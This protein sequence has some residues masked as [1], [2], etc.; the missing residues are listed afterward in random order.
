MRLS[1]QS[2]IHMKPHLPWPAN[3][4]IIIFILA[5]FLLPA[6]LAYSQE[7][8]SVDDFDNGL[9]NET[10][11]YENDIYNSNTEFDD[12]GAFAN[13]FENNAVQDSDQ[14]NSS[15]NQ[16]EF[17]QS[18]FEDP[19]A[20]E[21]AP[22]GADP[23]DGIVGQVSESVGR[24]DEFD[25]GLRAFNQDLRKALQSRFLRDLRRYC[26]DYCSL[27]SFDVASK[28]VFDAVNP[29]LGF[30][31]GASSERSFEADRVTADVLIDVRYGQRNTERLK[32][33]IDSVVRTYTFPIDV[34]WTPI[35]LP[36]SDESAKS[37][38]EVKRQ[39]SINIRAELERV[40]RDFCPDECS[41]T[42]LQ[43]QVEQASIDDI[44]DGSLSRYIF[45]RGARGSVYV[46][47]ASAAVS[48]NADMEEARRQRIENLLREVLHPY[49]SVN[50]SIRQMSFPRSAD[51]IRRDREAERTD[52]YGLEKLRQMLAIFK[53][54]A[55]TKEI[56]RETSLS[57]STARN[58]SSALNSTSSS[59]IKESDRTASLSEEKSSSDSRSETGLFGLSNEMLYIIG[60]LLLLLI[61]ASAVGLRFVMSGRRMQQVVDEGMSGQRVVGLAA[62]PGPMVHGGVAPAVPS[63]GS[64]GAGQSDDLVRMLE[65]QKIRDELIQTFLRQPKVAREVF[66]RIL[67][68]DGVQHA[69][70][71]V[72]IFGEIVTFELLDDNELKD[73]LT[74]LAEYV[75]KNVPRVEPK[76][77]L[78]ILQNL[79]LRV[80]AGKIKVLTTKGTGSF[81][82]LRAKSA[83]QIYNLIV[84]ENPES[85]SIVLTQLDKSKRNAVFDLFEGESKVGLLRALCQ[86]RTV[87]TEYLMSLADALRRKARRSGILD[88]GAMTGVDVLLDLLG[89]ANLSEQQNLMAELD[90]TNP[91]AARMVRSSLVTPETLQFIRDGLLIEV[92]L[93]LEPQTLGTFLAGCADHLRNLI[94]SK[95]P[96]EIAEDWYEMLSSIRSIDSENYRIAEMQI[97]TKVRSFSESGMINLLEINQSLFPMHH[98]NGF[99]SESERG[100]RSFRISQSIVA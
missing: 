69:A 8:D 70:K 9:S 76:E 92:F 26:L 58:E 72:S 5:V 81:D 35:E 93:G 91:E 18:A 42:D 79:K 86:G 20:E 29:D 85:Q 27:L 33:L 99:A 47:G 19:F 51:E 63:L 61:I 37:V 66:G 74:T 4:L 2:K 73:G 71:C 59:S 64:S 17:D 82:F 3:Y 44:S 98:Q 83:R 75:H 48:I 97:L 80:A 30:D 49:G 22:A 67:K 31:N 95:V 38:A 77:E 43:V 32:K 28:E 53:E 87:A 1:F 16:A 52:P 84:D 12:G 21:P 40:V 34:V 65:I 60:A 15:L 14:S 6:S 78:E 23:L 88:Q 54:F 62:M 57:E 46:K 36:E 24:E 41:I 55:G 10:D 39:F 94:L 25:K 96:R 90:A 13:S 11:N 68:E 50:L 100:R 89:Q 7:N 45:A 56:I